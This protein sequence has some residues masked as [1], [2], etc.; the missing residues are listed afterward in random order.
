MKSKTLTFLRCFS[1]AAFSC[2]LLGAC[3]GNK[4]ARAYQ[5]ESFT[6]ETPFQYYSNREPDVACEVAK[7]ALLSQGYQV[8][9]AKSRNIRG[10]KFFRPQQDQATTLSITLVCLPSSL[11]AVVYANGLETQYE[12]KSKGT[13]AGVSVAAVGSVSLPWAMDKDT[14][15]KIGEETITAPEFYQ[16][17]FDL[18]KTLDQ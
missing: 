11:G 7:R 5:T 1:L 14:L 9:D 10:E 6:S 13:N 3:A 15:V 17:L 4:S 8:D 18:F 16:R 12:M 2:L